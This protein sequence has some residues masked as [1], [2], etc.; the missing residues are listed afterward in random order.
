[1][2]VQGRVLF[3]VNVEVVA[4]VAG[5]PVVRDVLVVTV[6]VQRKA[7]GVVVVA[8]DAVAVAAVAEC[9]ADVDAVVE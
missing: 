1:M 6:A 9:E 3:Q 4:V 8:V 7:G 2:E 5:V